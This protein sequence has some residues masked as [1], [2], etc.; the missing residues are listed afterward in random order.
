MEIFSNVRGFKIKILYDVI[1]YIR[2]YILRF[3]VKM[4]NESNF[5]Y[6]F[7]VDLIMHA[8]H[9]YVQRVKYIIK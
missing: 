1:T 6:E 4:V 5:V 9:T 7:V 2:L 8:I 3:F